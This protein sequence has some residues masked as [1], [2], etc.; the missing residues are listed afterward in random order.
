MRL[1]GDRRAQRGWRRA[2]GWQIVLATLLWS[3]LAAAEVPVPELKT[4]VTDQTST[5]DGAALAA[6]E[7]RLA[8]FE[9]R[10]GSQIAVLVI[11]T[12]EPEAVEQYALR[13]AEAWMLGREGI[14]DGAL[15]LVA[16]ED[17]NVRIEVG[18][19]LEGALT[20]LAS[21]RIISE[22]I[23]PRF[24][25][26]D[27]PGGI[28]LGVERM[29]AVAEGEP[30]PEPQPNWEPGP[31]AGLKSLFPFLLI[32]AFIAGGFLRMLFGRFW[33]SLAGATIAGVIVWLLS[34]LLMVGLVAGII[35][36]VIMLLGGA[37]AGGGRWSSHPRA[38]GR[39]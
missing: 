10:T 17:R 7:E 30:L 34:S 4:R 24:R 15:L 38:G 35:T 25:S 8:A 22:S 28:E 16:L 6:L 23:L 19:G 26:G 33:G 1:E 27:V 3:G 13:V 9:S 14:D 21:R 36:F 32:V 18:Y 2:L 12:T 39:S 37:R 11:P 5:L 31:W 20:D 29:I